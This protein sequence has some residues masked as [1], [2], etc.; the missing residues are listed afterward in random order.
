[1]DL[2]EPTIRSGKLKP[3]MAML[4]SCLISA[5]LLRV[6][7]CLIA[8]GSFWL[9][10]KEFVML[11]E[12]ETFA[13]VASFLVFLFVCFPII[14]ASALFCAEHVLR[15]ANEWTQILGKL[16]LGVVFTFMGIAF[17]I[18]VLVLSSLIEHAIYP[19]KRPE[20]QP[21]KE[22]FVIRDL[23]P[24]AVCLTGSWNG[25]WRD[26]TRKRTEAFR[27]TLSMTGNELS[28]QAVFRDANSTKADITGQVSGTKIRM[29]MTP[30]PTAP[31]HF[32]SETTWIG[33]SSNG[34]ISGT[35]HLHARQ[36]YDYATTGPWSA[37]QQNEETASPEE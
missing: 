26:R 22:T 5:V 15:N 20:V 19:V 36:N 9:S 21:A 16:V 17:V 18:A 8:Y 32:I 34:T 1:M 29:L 4:L 13:L 28:G 12:Q 35:W 7:F 2:Q 23:K 14:I 6:I 24:P 33:V 3:W 25:F 11:N 31:F 10:A 27:F 30:H 37:T